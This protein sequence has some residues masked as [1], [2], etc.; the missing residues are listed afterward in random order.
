VDGAG[1]IERAEVDAVFVPYDSVEIL[2]P[3]AQVA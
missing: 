3:L 2:V 1:L